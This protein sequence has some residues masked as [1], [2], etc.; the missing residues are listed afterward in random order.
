MTVKYVDGYVACIK[1]NDGSRFING[2]LQFFSEPFPSEQEALDWAWAHNSIAEGQV[3]CLRVERKQVPENQ[4]VRPLI[5][6]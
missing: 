5:R 3:D 4:L 6:G 1:N 2:K